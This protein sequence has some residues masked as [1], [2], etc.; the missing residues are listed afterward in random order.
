MCACGCSAVRCECEV[1]C[2]GL[3]IDSLL[4]SSLLVCGVCVVCGCVWC[5]GCV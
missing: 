3:C 5:V 4:L 1:V 2:V